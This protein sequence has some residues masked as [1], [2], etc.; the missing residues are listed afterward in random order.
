MGYN[1]R[2]SIRRSCGASL[3]LKREINW[4]IKRPMCPGCGK[5]TL[6]TVNKREK[7]RNKKRVCRCD[8]YH[9]PHSKGTEPWCKHSKRSPSDDDYAQRY[10]KLDMGH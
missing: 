10:Y 1:Y 6:K 2:C 3:T 4:Y 9:Y 8:G 7:D 5:D